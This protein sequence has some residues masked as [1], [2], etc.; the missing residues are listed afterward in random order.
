MCQLCNDLEFPTV[1][2]IV[3]EYGDMFE[4]WGGFAGFCAEND[5]YL[6]NIR[7]EVDF[8]VFVGEKRKRDE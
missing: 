3:V 8:E 2:E 7:D 5:L 6:D 1:P 4:P